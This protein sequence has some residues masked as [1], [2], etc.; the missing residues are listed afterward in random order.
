MNIIIIYASIHHG[1]TKKIA[2]AIHSQLGGRLINFTEVKKEDIVNA[3]LIGFGSG[4][5]MVKFHTALLGFIKSLPFMEN[6]KCFIFSTAGIRKNIFLNKGNKSAKK[7]LKN[8][9]F[10]IV[11]EF[12]CLGHDTYGPLKLIGG[13]NK[14]RPNEK[15]LEDARKFAESIILDRVKRK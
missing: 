1:N 2:E 14:G 11:G 12:D 3:D 4:I 13:I 7:I 8:K 6:K 5:Y 9:G 10:E 15:D